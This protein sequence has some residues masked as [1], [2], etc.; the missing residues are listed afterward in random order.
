MQLP[1]FPSSY[2]QALWKE[3]LLQ[4]YMSE[5]FTGEEDQ[6]GVMEFLDQVEHFG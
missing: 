2:D 5:L 3:Q 1:G 6:M 4:K